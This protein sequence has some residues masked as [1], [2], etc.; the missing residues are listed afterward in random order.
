MLSELFGEISQKMK[1]D[2]QGITSRIEH[3]GEKG[4][5]RENTLENALRKYIPDK[6]IFSKGMIIDSK[7]EQSRQVDI[8]IHDKMLSPIL[9]NLESTRIIPIESVYGVIEVKSRLTKNELAKAIKNIESVRR[10]PKKTMTGM[11]F[12]TFGYLFAYDSD[13]SLETVYKNFIELS[14]EV[15]ADHQ[16]SCICVLN[17]G[18]IIPL[19]KYNLLTIKLFPEEDTVFAIFNDGDNALLIFYLI[20]F[21]TLNSIMVFP[22]NMLEYAQSSGSLK[23]SFIIPG[24]Y[25]PEDATFSYL[26]QSASIRDLNNMQK[27]GEKHFS[28]ELQ[29]EEFLECEFGLL[30][31]TIINTYGALDKVPE[32]VSFQYFDISLNCKEFL[33]MYNIYIRKETASLKELDRLHTY[34]TKLYEIYDCHRAEMKGKTIR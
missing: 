11:S 19:D 31:P 16:I 15:T 33:H 24:G 13:S 2:F 26:G 14:K 4:I 25:I 34:E 1:I 8:I 23:S 5:A 17:K 20:L 30:I 3:N 18:L 29:K 10:L 32:D 6:Y 22:P 9:L 21:Q 27:L 7:D 12:P 28:G